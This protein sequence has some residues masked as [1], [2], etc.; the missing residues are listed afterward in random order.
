MGKELITGSSQQY[1][2]GSAGDSD[3]T[4]RTKRQMNCK[5]KLSLSGSDRLG[6]IANVNGNPTA[7]AGKSSLSEKATKY[8]A[9]AAEPPVKRE[10][11]E[12][13][14]ANKEDGGVLENGEDKDPLDQVMLNLSNFKKERKALLCKQMELNEKENSVA[15]LKAQIEEREC[16]LITRLSEFE[17]SDATQ[18]QKEVE[19]KEME[20]EIK[21][22]ES[23][24]REGEIKLRNESEKIKLQRNALAEEQKSRKSMESIQ[25]E[26]KALEARCLDLEQKFANKVH[27]S[28]MLKSE[29]EEL[30]I[31]LE[32]ERK[33]NI[34]QTDAWQVQRTSDLRGDLLREKEEIAKQLEDLKNSRK[35]I[36][37]DKAKQDGMAKVRY[38]LF[39]L[40][41][42]TNLNFCAKVLE[43][44]RSELQAA[45]EQT[46]RRFREA[47]EHAHKFIDALTWLGP[48]SSQVR[49]Q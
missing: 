49:S 8:G 42:G 48:N 31:K 34:I 47:M 23:S 33:K 26:K 25:L 21:K 36:E 3:A 37:E 30:K 45:E 35:K 12:N 38:V 29:N 10:G 22:R 1:S 6:G 2:D 16:L 24:L 40:V 32:S 27:N 28:E 19:L 46:R 4:L 43:D 15:A 39:S 17:K 14:Q 9:S 5:K 20:A 41:P 44:Q 7:V 18:K 13:I 11:S